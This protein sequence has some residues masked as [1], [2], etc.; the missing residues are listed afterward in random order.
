MVDLWEE[1]DEDK[2]A[3]L[4][5]YVAAGIKD[6]PTGGATKLN[7]ILYFAEFGHIRSHGRP[8]TGDPYQKLPKGP[9][10]RH[11]VPVRDRL[12]ANG[13][14]EMV[15]DTYF[16][17]A[18]NRLVPLR[19][20]DVIRFVESEMQA[21]DK[22]VKALWGKTAGWASELSHA[23]KAWQ[24]VDEGEDI[25]FSTAFLAQRSI[26]TEK[27]RDHARALAEKLGILR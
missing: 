7:K 20:A 17:R 19:D 2:L 12:I 4:I 21:V 13:D 8:I 9:A 1:A 5:L 26:V 25:P 11:L 23:D 15:H 22:V 24:L 3:E 14:A 10:P 16:G 27:S 6:D 18:L